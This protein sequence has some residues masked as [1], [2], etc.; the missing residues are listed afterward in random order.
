MNGIDVSNNGKA[1][2]GSI[3]NFREVIKINTALLY[4]KA[5]VSK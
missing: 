4:Q 5:S 1:D 2:V 3:L